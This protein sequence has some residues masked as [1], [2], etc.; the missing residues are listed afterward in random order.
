MSDQTVLEQA[1]FNGVR[2]VHFFNGRVLTAEDLQEE[3]YANHLRNWQ[4]GRV[5]GEGIVDGFTV[6]H[7]VGGAGTASIDVAPGMAINRM[8]QVLDLRTVASVDLTGQ[9]KQ[10]APVRL[11]G[12]VKPFKP[13]GAL[14]LEASDETITTGVYLLVAYPDVKPTGQAPRVEYNNFNWAAACG[15]RYMEEEIA[16]RLIEIRYSDVRLPRLLQGYYKELMQVPNP[17]AYEQSR[18]RNLVAHAFLGTFERPEGGFRVFGEQHQKTERVTYGPLDSLR[19]R[20]RDRLYDCE[21]PL[22]LVQTVD[23]TIVAV[24]Q[25]SVRRR[26][27]RISGASPLNVGMLDRAE[28]EAEAT[29]MQF[30]EQID[31]YAGDLSSDGTDLQ[32][33]AR[34]LF[35]VMPAAGLLTPGMSSATAFFDGL[36]TVGPAFLTSTAVPGLLERIMMYP[37]VV[38]GENHTFMLYQARAPRDISDRENPFTLTK[39]QILFIS[40]TI[41]PS[42]LERLI[43]SADGDGMLSEEASP[44]AITL[45]G[46]NQATI[47]AGELEKPVDFFFE[48]VSQLPLDGFFELVPLV[49]VN[50]NSR[51]GTP[52]DAWNGALNT[53]INKGSALHLTKLV[54]LVPGEKK[55][56]VVRL[57]GIPEE[58]TNSSFNIGLQVKARPDLNHNLAEPRERIR[59]DTNNLTSAA[60]MPNEEG[61][62]TTGDHLIAWDLTS[63]DEVW[64]FE[65]TGSRFICMAISENGNW[66]AAGDEAGVVRVWNMANLQEPRTLSVP[67]NDLNTLAFFVKEKDAA[68]ENLAGGDSM[69]DSAAAWLAIGGKELVLWQF[70][71]DDNPA[72]VVLGRPHASSSIQCLAFVLM[73]SAEASRETADSPPEDQENE[74]FLIS[75][76]KSPELVWWENTET[77]WEQVLLDDATNTSRALTIEAE[78]KLADISA[79]IFDRN[80]ENLACVSD[81]LTVL[82]K[83][84]LGRFSVTSSLDKSV[85]KGSLLH[86]SQDG[87]YLYAVEAGKGISA[88][89]AE[90]FAFSHHYNKPASSAKALALLEKHARLITVYDDGAILVWNTAKSP[91]AW[92]LTDELNSDLIADHNGVWFAAVGKEHRISIWDQLSGIEHRCIHGEVE[93]VEHLALSENGQYLATAGHDISIWHPQ[94]GTLVKK[95]PRTPDATQPLNQVLAVE[96]NILASID[97]KGRAILWNRGSGEVEQLL[98]QHADGKSDT[99]AISSNG[100]WVASA[101]KSLKIWHIAETDANGDP[102]SWELTDLKHTGPVTDIA[103]SL[104]PD[105]MYMVTAGENPYAVLWKKDGR[106]WIEEDRLLLQNQTKIDL[107]FPA[108]QEL[109]VEEIRNEPTSHFIE[110]SAANAVAVC[111]VT[112]R[113]AVGGRKVFIWDRENNKHILTSE[114]HGS[115]GEGGAIT[116]MTFTPSGEQLITCSDVDGQVILWNAG[117]G[118]VFDRLPISR[119]FKRFALNETG[120]HLLTF[121]TDGKVSRWALSNDSLPSTQEEDTWEKQLPA[122]SDYIKFVTDEEIVAVGSR[123]ESRDAR[124]GKLHTRTVQQLVKLDQLGISANGTRLVMGLTDALADDASNKSL[125]VQAWQKEE[126]AYVD[127]SVGLINDRF[128]ISADGRYLASLT[129]AKVV[130]ADGESL[131]ETIRLTVLHD[132]EAATPVNLLTLASTQSVRMMRF[133]PAG[134]RL[135]IAMKN[136]LDGQLLMLE[137][138]SGRQLF[139][140][141][142]AAQIA[143]L[144]FT[145][146]GELLAIALN[147]QSPESTA[148]S[149]V[150]IRDASLG[151]PLFSAT[152]SGERFK[153]VA[154]NADETSLVASVIPAPQ[155][156][157]D[158]LPELRES[159]FSLT[160]RHLPLQAASYVQPVRVIVGEAL[161]T[162]DPGIRIDLM[163]LP[164]DGGMVPVDDAG[165]PVLAPGS[166]MVRVCSLRGGKLSCKIVLDARM[167]QWSVDLETYPMEASD[168]SGNTVSVSEM[169]YVSGRLARRHVQYL[170]LDV[171]STDEAVSSGLAELVVERVQNGHRVRQVLPLKIFKETSVSF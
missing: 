19:E 44:V 92:T 82:S 128:A 52:L 57:Q 112:G 32:A 91:D 104:K 35:H 137:L 29:I 160:T 88:W 95:L 97:G 90:S 61:V 125:V 4:L 98:G 74:L 40:E 111:P 81:G 130:E 54:Y 70:A 68:R 10:P 22:A 78:A 121:E 56:V 3:Q 162:R 94:K 124:T 83:D 154:F 67:V 150:E 157:S 13:C 148:E 84:E 140:L 146:N 158:S 64:R 96:G 138:K 107:T 155:L 62:I 11:P 71:N 76:G 51:T 139:S 20:K 75:G 31:A 109:D 118:E 28:A 113:I 60:F 38:L 12:R 87:R 171:L 1:P 63:G 46:T 133:D 149:Y 25:W 166:Y 86:Y 48:I 34:D 72:H 163:A 110:S 152:L 136:D 93:E 114:G 144:D 164:E 115:S 6:R 21:V 170:K 145:A 23:T 14:N 47:T 99:L 73:A 66:L 26:L 85:Q 122:D 65:G 129:S 15:Q 50:D 126:T 151:A 119:S 156:T 108:P 106:D 168:G 33:R 45:L 134:K 143:S 165:V 55:E 103:F 8:G 2:N 69:L 24:D 49:S 17:S 77:G 42:E 131:L 37:P 36:S 142:F 161:D 116:Q 123:I 153:E 100:D 169:A 58:E 167:N 41:N 39:P 7:N 80:A 16:Y 79:M 159:E 102:K 127:T 27:H 141:S 5:L 132:G 59:L 53:M 43:A 135:V 30:Q 117:T 120:T 18:L 89:E 101:G 105:A 9:I 147:P